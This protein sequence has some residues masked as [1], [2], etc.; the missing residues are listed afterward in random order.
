MVLGTACTGTPCASCLRTSTAPEPQRGPRWRRRRGR[1]PRSYAGFSDFH[2]GEKIRGHADHP[3][4]APWRS[5]GVVARADVI[6]MLTP[7]VH[8]C[9]EDAVPGQDVMVEASV[10]ARATGIP[11]RRVQG[12][13][14]RRVIRPAV[15]GAGRGSRRRFSRADCVVLAVIDQLQ[16]IL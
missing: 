16:V 15:A 7:E 10:A 12:W 5:L 11:Q 14:A 6:S 13:A 1:E 9:F 8:M 4:V 2:Q 3:A